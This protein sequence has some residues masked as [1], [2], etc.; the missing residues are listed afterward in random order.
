MITQLP[1]ST[2]NVLKELDKTR[3]LLRTDEPVGSKETKRMR[4]DTSAENE[5]SLDKSWQRVAIILDAIPSCVTPQESHQLVPTLF[6]L[7]ERYGIE[8]V[9]WSM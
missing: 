8:V 7:L 5:V 4:L 2:S 9:I 3:Q 1:L 6:E